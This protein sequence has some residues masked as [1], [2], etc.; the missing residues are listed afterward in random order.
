MKTG[1][2]PSVLVLGI[3]LLQLQCWTAKDD[4][5]S[6]AWLRFFGDKWMPDSFSGRL[7]TSKTSLGRLFPWYFVWND[8]LDQKNIFFMPLMGS[9]C[10]EYSLYRHHGALSDLL[11]RFLFMYCPICHFPCQPLPIGI[12]ESPRSVK[13]LLDN[14]N[15]AHVKAF[16]CTFLRVLKSSFIDLP[17]PVLGPTPV[18]QI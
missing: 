9:I 13:K 5:F 8:F 14:V 1:L 7:E 18:L 3:V 15:G 16:V 2:A 10:I 12:H 11:V 6:S 4:K 17:V